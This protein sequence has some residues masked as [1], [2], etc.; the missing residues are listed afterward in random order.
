LAEATGNLDC[1][2]EHASAALGQARTMGAERLSAELDARV[3]SLSP[4]DAR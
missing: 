2:A 4:V 3:Q 1:A